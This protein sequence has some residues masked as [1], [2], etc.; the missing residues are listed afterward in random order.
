MHPVTSCNADSSR[1]PKE[2]GL[3]AAAPVSALVGRVPIRDRMLLIDP[4]ILFVT[5]LASR[6]FNCRHGLADGLSDFFVV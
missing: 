4:P 5:L 1:K 6:A 2:T 3:H